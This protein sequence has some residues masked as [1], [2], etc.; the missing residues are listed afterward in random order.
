VY[1]E[2]GAQQLLDVQRIAVGARVDRLGEV[3]A[4]RPVRAERR[5]EHLLDLR[6]VEPRQV[7]LAR[8]APRVR[9]AATA[10]RSGRSCSSSLR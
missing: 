10:P 4:D 7:Q 6:E 1:L 2:Q 3:V 9:S 5:V 8:E